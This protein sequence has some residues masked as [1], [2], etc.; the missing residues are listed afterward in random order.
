MNKYKATFIFPSFLSEEALDKVLDR[1]CEEIEKVGGAVRARKVVGKRSF[2]RPLK[3]HEHGIYVRLRLELPPT[4]ID[5]LLGRFKLNDDVFRVQILRDESN[6][7]E[8]VAEEAAPVAAA[9]ETVEPVAAAPEAAEVA[10][11]AGEARND[12]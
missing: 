2:A 12:G 1:V 10:V 5:P 6:A 8:V 7:E 4:A 3:K 11:P 9:T